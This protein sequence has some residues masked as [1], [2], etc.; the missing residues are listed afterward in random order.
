[1]SSAML[2]CPAA[3]TYLCIPHR[4]MVSQTQLT[5]PALGGSSRS[6]MLLDIQDGSLSTVQ[7]VLGGRD[8]GILGV[9]RAESLM[10]MATSMFSEWV[11]RNKGRHLLSTWANPQIFSSNFYM[12]IMAYMCVHVWVLTHIHKHTPTR[13]CTH[14]HT[15]AYTYI[16]THQQIYIHIHITHTC[17]HIRTNTYTCIYIPMHIHTHIH[18]H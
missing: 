13:T 18:T 11:E 16:Y 5:Q 1:M 2:L 3:H 14:I 7:R 15:N 12:A 8:W 6:T 9:C 10:E 4:T 17:T